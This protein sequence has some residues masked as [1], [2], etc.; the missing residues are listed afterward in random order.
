MDYSLRQAGRASIEFLVDLR[1][2]SD[3]LEEHADR[4]ADA[5]GL[6]DTSDAPASIG[7]DRMNAIQ[8]RLAPAMQESLDFRVLRLMRDWTLEQHGAIAMEA[9]EEMRADIEPR[10]RELQRGPTAIRYAPALT[11]PNY[12]DG[13]EFHR[14]TG[15]WDGHD[16]MGFVHGE[17]IH[18]KMVGESVADAIIDARRAT[19]K[20]PPL[21]NPGRIL[22]IGCGSAQYTLGL[23]A[24]W[25]D[26]EL[27][28]CDLSPRQLEQAQR[29]AN[30]LGL[31]WNLFVAAAEDTGLDDGQFDLVTSFAIFH[32]FPSA[33][34]ARVLG[35][36]Y[37]LLKPGGWVLM[38][39]VR[40]YHVQD[41]WTRWKADFWNQV[42]GGEP[43]WREYATT[44]LA[45]LARDAG[46]SDAR[47]FGVEPADYPFVLM[48]RKP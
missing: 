44:D 27:W 26:S 9:F 1:R 34:A 48:G 3:R 10:L 31:Q 43:Y 15:G 22:E 16:F 42:H 33:V 37:R 4:F 38:A 23:A 45:A 46:F 5:S 2:Q 41:T 19:A 6:R 18:R 13:Y 36:A 47:W 25:P 20:M 14:S 21:Q 11:P 30:E 8:R 24:A 39:D 17:L 12:W 40:A 29:H 7:A 28:A 32:E 35:E